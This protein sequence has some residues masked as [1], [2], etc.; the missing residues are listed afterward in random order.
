MPSIRHVSGDD[1][2]AMR[3]VSLL[4]DEMVIRYEDPRSTGPSPLHSRA[5]WLLVLDDSGLPIGVGA[6]QPLI[7]TVASAEG[8]EGEIKRVYIAT[9]ARG[10]GASRVLMAA[11]E[12]VAASEGWVRL[13][14]ETGLRQPEAL[15]LYSSSGWTSTTPYGEYKDAEES[16]SFAKDLRANL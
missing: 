12:D 11:L 4:H 2:D 14:L 8:D 13:R 1:P 10:D 6:V 9:E 15:A 7:H 5:R 3:F 16:R